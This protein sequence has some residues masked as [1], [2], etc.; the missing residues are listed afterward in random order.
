MPSQPPAGVRGGGERDASLRA[1]GANSTPI[2]TRRA[3]GE[4]ASPDLWAKALHTVKQLR[5]RVGQGGF[6]EDT[7]AAGLIEETAANS[8]ATPTERRVTLP[9]HYRKRDTKSYLGQPSGPT[10]SGSLPPKHRRERGLQRLYPQYNLV[11]S[12]CRKHVPQPERERKEHN[13]GQIR[14]RRGR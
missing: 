5:E 4:T 1:T 3:E 9:R 11:R 14:E 13:Q 12:L 10:A 7:V 8:T 2:T 6:H